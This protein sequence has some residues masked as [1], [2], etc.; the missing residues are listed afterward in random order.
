LG[1]S[2]Y[3]SFSPSLSESAVRQYFKSLICFWSHY[4]HPN[5]LLLAGPSVVH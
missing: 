1:W 2:T 3:V 5:F 4:V